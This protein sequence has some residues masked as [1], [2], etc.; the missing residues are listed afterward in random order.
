MVKRKGAYVPERGDAV[1]IT[2]DPQAG[3]EQ[4]GRRPALVL[5]PLA[6]NR[7]VDLALLCPITGQAKGYPFEVAL[8]EGLAVSGVTLADQ[9]KSLD[10]RVRKATRICAVPEEVVA[11]VLQRL[12]LLLA[13]HAS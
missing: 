2:L 11:Q 9:V 1:W 13:G 6:Y 5:S 10:W 12:N 7:R 4:A 8:P 3:H